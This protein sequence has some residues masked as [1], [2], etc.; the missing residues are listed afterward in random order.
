MIVPASEENRKRAGPEL[1]P[2]CTTNPVEPL[3]TV[4]VGAPPG[5]ET[6]SGTLATGVAPTPPEYSV[7]TSVPLSATQA[8]VVGPNDSPH[9]LTRLGSSQL[10]R[11]GDVGDEVALR[12]APERRG[13]RRR[14]ASAGGGERK[15]DRPRQARACRTTSPTVRDAARARD[16]ERMRNPHGSGGRPDPAVPRDIRSEPAARSAHVVVKTHQISLMYRGARERQSGPGESSP[17]PFLRLAGHRLRWRLLSE[18]ARS[19]RRVGELSALAGRPQSLVSYHLGQLRDGGLVSMRR[20]AADGRD[21]YYALDLARCGE[22]LASAGGSLH[23]GLGPAAAPAGRA[24]ASRAARVLF[25]CTGNSAR[26]QM[27]EALAEQLSGGAVERGQRGQ[28]SQ[29]A[30]SRTRCA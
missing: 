1:V 18:L 8:G 5:I 19:D 21:T 11:A 7:D 15:P 27:A 24:R 2:E 28:P 12:V 29:A 10:R 6:V 20:S 22:L 3:K 16:D 13:R 26:S 30:A 23:P 17:P 9:A 14:C 25:L 4:P